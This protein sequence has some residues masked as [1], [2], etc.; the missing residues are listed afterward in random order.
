MSE[1]DSDEHLSLEGHLLV[2]SPELNDPNFARS[3]VLI[4]QH[5]AAGAFGLVLTQSTNVSVEQV[6]QKVS[7]STCRTRDA[8][9]RG[10]P[11][12]GP[13][14]ALHADCEIGGSEILSGAFYSVAAQ[15]IEN[16]V[17]SNAQP[18]RFFIGYS[19]WGDGQLE[20]EL[21][22]GGWLIVR[23]RPEDLFQSIDG[24]WEATLRR[25]AGQS[26]LKSMGIDDFPQDL[27]A[28]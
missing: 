24:F 19:G 8:I 16:L 20:S 15:Q 7:E 11:V 2:A 1:S 5:N 3:V 18:A 27:S 23:A 25:V 14:M 9:H 28:N 17:V 10:G 4:I 21:E 12:D 22:A 13:L 6:W 26:V